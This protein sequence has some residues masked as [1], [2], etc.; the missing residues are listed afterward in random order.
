MRLLTKKKKKWCRLRR[1]GG[2][3]VRIRMHT[4]TVR[5]PTSHP[6]HDI[7]SYSLRCSRLAR[8]YKT[9]LLLLFF[10]FNDQK[11]YTLQ[12]YKRRKQQW[13]H[14]ALPLVPLLLCC[15]HSSPRHLRAA[16][17]RSLADEDQIVFLRRCVV[18][19]LAGF[20]SLLLGGG[21]QGFC[22][23]STLALVSLRLKV[24]QNR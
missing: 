3:L 9:C 18:R 5:S 1:S 12:K 16:N 24:E 2:V 8:L 4:C 23:L 14:A 21:A 15:C 17:A 13:G 6:Q 7:D 10:A 11:I 20:F 19:G 22:Q